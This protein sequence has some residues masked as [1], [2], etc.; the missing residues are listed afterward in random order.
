MDKPPTSANLAEVELGPT[1]AHQCAGNKK[2]NNARL[3]FLCGT[4]FQ[5]GGLLLGLCQ[6][7]F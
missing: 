3:D 5:T 7:A 4:T 1:A 6:S 2:G